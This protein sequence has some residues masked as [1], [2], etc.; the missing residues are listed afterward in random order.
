MM[1]AVTNSLAPEPA[2]SSLYLQASAT[3]PYPK[4]TGSTL[5]APQPMSQSYILI[6]SFHLRL[7][8]ASGLF[9]SS[10]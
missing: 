9:P 4:T 7:G 5:H 3:G 6:P 10:A 1:Q 2:G 8:L